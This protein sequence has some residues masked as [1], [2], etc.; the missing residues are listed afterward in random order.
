MP[1]FPDSI[2]QELRT[3]LSLQCRDALMT[4]KAD[5]EK[6]VVQDEY[7]FKIFYGSETHASVL[8][9]FM[10][11]K[12]PYSSAFDKVDLVNNREGNEHRSADGYM[13]QLREILHCDTSKYLLVDKFM[14]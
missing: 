11:G 3:L 14:L 6:K 12:E 10:E 5:G 2:I 13:L 1:A 4:Q 7:V 9:Q 8:K